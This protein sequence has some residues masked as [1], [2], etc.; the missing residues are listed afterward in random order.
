MSGQCGICQQ[1]SDGCL[2]DVTVKDVRAFRK[3]PRAR[4]VAARL[5]I[6]SPDPRWRE[7]YEYV[8]TEK[9]VEVYLLA[10]DKAKY[11]R[12]NKRAILG[13][14]INGE[15]KYFNNYKSMV[16][17]KNGETIQ[18]MFRNP[19]SMMRLIEQRH[20]DAYYETEAVLDHYVQHKNTAPFIAKL[21]IK[22]LVTSNPTPNYVLRVAQAF[23]SGRYVINGIEFGDGT[24][25][26]LESTFAAILLDAE[27]R[28]SN[29]DADPTF[30]SLKEPIL[31]LFAFMRAMEFKMNDRVPTLRMIGM[32]NKI[33]QEPFAAPNVFSCESHLLFCLSRDSRQKLTFSTASK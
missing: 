22:R 1:L 15:M 24:N 2:C 17:I 23:R 25:G 32:M 4:K 27:A 3:V 10:K 20:S 14:P 13:V 30:G 18:Y 19:V 31:K 8:A 7:N 16:H 29:L 26:N 21:M 12:L 6:A 28:N 33:G 5:T 11:P 9:G